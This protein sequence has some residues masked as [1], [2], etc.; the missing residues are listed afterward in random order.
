MTN[1]YKEAGVDIE[2]GEKAV[3][4]IKKHVK[5]TYNNSVIGGIGNFG[6]MI[7]TSFLREYK[8]PVL[9]QSIDGVGTKIDVAKMTGV[10]TI[11]QCLV[12]HC[13]NDILTLGAKPISFT[14][15]I[16]SDKLDPKVVEEIVK[17]M[18]VAC[19]EYCINLNTSLPIIAGETAEM[20]C[21][22][23]S[24]QYDVVGSITGV[25]EKSKIIDGSKI[26]E[27]D[28]LIGLPSNG[29]H[30][31]GYSLA[32]KVF[33]EI[34]DYNIDDYALGLEDCTVGEELM[35]VHKCYFN[36]VDIVLS[37]IEVRGIA[38]I[39][40]GGFDNIGRL[41]RDGLCAEVNEKWD[42]PK[43]FKFI[44][45]RGDVSDKEMR[46]VFNLGIGMV[47]IV[48]QESWEKIGS[49]LR[50]FCAGHTRIGKIKKAETEKKVVF[51]Y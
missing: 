17:N 7:D 9:V 45:K 14:N 34:R 49:R 10:Y 28:I 5:S 13:I 15:Y 8:N 47:L 31:N 29:L 48:P 39:T 22:Y 32:R 50:R 20:G 36:E 25:V 26:K 43:V 3:D 21:V 35:K 16:A 4:L 40:G 24:G 42:I 41:L 27:G 6:G 51:T 46:K 12:N 33:F 18:A 2:A 38:H 30:T 1:A 19:N 44:K 37:N 11:G 23:K